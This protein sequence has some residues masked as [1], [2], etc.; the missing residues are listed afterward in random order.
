M[1]VHI[2]LTSDKQEQ[3]STHYFVDTETTGLSSNEHVITEF[4]CIKCVD[5][6]EVDRLHLRVIPTEQELDRADKRALET[7]KFD[8]GLW[9]RTGLPSVE[10]ANRIAA[11]LRGGHGTAIIAHNARF[12]IRFIREL[13]KNTNNVFL[14][15]R[16]I[17][18]ISIA[19]SQFD[20]L[21]LKSMSFDSIRDFLGWSADGAHTAIKDAEDVMRLYQLL[22]P[23]PSASGGVIINEVTRVSHIYGVRL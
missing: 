6:V 21:G 3:M 11:F 19:Y 17:D 15:T 5:G 9:N 18:T 8:L 12:D 7:H 22:S 16:C 10:A 2:I 14:P 13:L 20:A 4:A 1:N 23:R